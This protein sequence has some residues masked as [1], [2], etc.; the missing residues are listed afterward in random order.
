MSDVTRPAVRSWVPDDLE[1]EPVRPGWLTA[2]PSTIDLA[3]PVD[4]RDQPLVSPD[5]Q[6][7][8]RTVRFTGFDLV[9]GE[10]M[11]NAVDRSLSIRRLLQDGRGL[12]ADEVLRIRALHKGTQLRPELAWGG[13]DTGVG[14][15]LTRLAHAQQAL[16]ADSAGNVRELRFR[17]RIQGIGLEECLVSYAA[18]ELV[19][20]L[21][22]D[23]TL[24]LDVLCHADLEMTNEVILKLGLARAFSQEVE[25]PSTSSNFSEDPLWP[26]ICRVW[27]QEMAFA[28]GVSK[29][30][31]EAVIRRGRSDVAGSGVSVRL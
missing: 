23:P 21:V 31:A 24:S 28:K 20:P 15:Q 19:D 9:L 12:E 3:P 11:R 14:E 16:T 6:A 30:W 18:T 25:Y 4:L 26:V 8:F 22:L 27:E 17:L 2:S 5:D 13:P 1:G 29:R 10:T 7:V